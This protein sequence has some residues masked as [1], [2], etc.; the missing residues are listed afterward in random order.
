[1]FGHLVLKQSI[2]CLSQK[3]LAMDDGKNLRRQLATEQCW[4]DADQEAPQQDDE[5]EVVVL[6]DIPKEE[7]ARGKQKLATAVQLKLLRVH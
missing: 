3:I 1:M 4:Y 7:E 6:R 2:Q 5:V